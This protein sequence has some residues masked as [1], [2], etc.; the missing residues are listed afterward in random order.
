M[1][2]SLAV[3]CIAA[4]LVAPA[5]PSDFPLQGDL[6]QVRRR[7]MTTVG[8]DQ[9]D[10]IDLEIQGRYVPATVTTREGDTVPRSGEIRL[11]DAARPNTWD[12]IEFIRPQRPGD[13]DEP[14]DLPARRRLP[15]D[16]QRRPRPRPSELKPGEDGPPH[17]LAIRRIR[18]D[19]G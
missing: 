16:P 19:E 11:N 12:W 17:V 10:P 6:T 13:A 2:L 18:E 14:G 5:S 4:A 9:D 7:C 15:D 8:P 3:P 1:G